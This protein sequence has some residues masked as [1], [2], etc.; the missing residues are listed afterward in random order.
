MGRTSRSKIW[1]DGES[2]SYGNGDFSEKSGTK[3][4][5]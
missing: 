1:R 2:V 4:D 3:I 5:I